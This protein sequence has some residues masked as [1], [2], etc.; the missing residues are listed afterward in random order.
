MAS[1]NKFAASCRWFCR[2][3][4]MVSLFSYFEIVV[5]ING[6]LRDGGRYNHPPEIAKL[7]EHLFFIFI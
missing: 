2:I 6:F 4:S 7:F 3:E 5:K 1:K